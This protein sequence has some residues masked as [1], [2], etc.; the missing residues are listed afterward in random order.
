MEE[1][2]IFLFVGEKLFVGLWVGAVRVSHG[3]EGVVEGA[4]EVSSWALL[5]L[6][7]CLIDNLRSRQKGRIV[8]VNQEAKSTAIREGHGQIFNLRNKSQFIITNILIGLVP[9]SM[10]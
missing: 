10:P 5:L 8:M 4:V 9:T 2:E 6:L 3:A 1:L 7:G